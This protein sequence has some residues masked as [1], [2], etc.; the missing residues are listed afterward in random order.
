MSKGYIGVTS[1]EW[2]T[3]LKENNITQEVN[4]WRK[5]TNNFRV[6]EFG[7]PFFFLVKNDKNTKSERYVLGYG[8]YKRFEVL[9]IDKAWD[10]YQ[11]GNGTSSKS[12]YLDRMRNLFKKNS[13]DIGCIILDNLKFFDKP[14]I[15]SKSG[16]MFDNSVVSGKGI[17]NE[18]VNQITSD[19]QSLFPRVFNSWEI[20]SNKIALKTIDKSVFMH[21]GTGIPIGTR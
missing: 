15:L 7:E 9:D 13:G 14:V 3:Y 16:I 11:I 18:E 19:I 4:F 10:K 6:L 2:F 17:N 20:L 8:V 21:H 5:N 1:R 12:E